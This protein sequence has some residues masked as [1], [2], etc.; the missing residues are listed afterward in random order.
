MFKGETT[1]EQVDQLTEMIRRAKIARDNLVE[2]LT[3]EDDVVQQ[4]GP[5]PPQRPTSTKSG[6]VP[7]NMPKFRQNGP[8]K[9]PGEFLEAFNTVMEAHNI[10]E[11]RY[12]SLMKLC[13]EQVDARW[14]DMVPA[15]TKANWKSLSNFHPTFPTSTSTQHAH[16]PN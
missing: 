6:K 10:P 16:G 2:I 14:L 8:Y 4:P 11:E 1:L 9:E 15:Q 7:S 12:G 5:I 13:L 3:L